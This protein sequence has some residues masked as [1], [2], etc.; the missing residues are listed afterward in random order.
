[1]RGVESNAPDGYAEGFYG[2]KLILG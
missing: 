1:L 2:R